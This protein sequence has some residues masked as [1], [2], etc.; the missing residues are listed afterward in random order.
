M[1]IKFLLIG[2]SLFSERIK[3][4]DYKFKLISSLNKVFPGVEPGEDLE[5]I[6]LSGFW[7][8]TISLQCAYRADSLYTGYGRL[9]V[10]G[11][12]KDAVRIREVKLMPSV[13]PCNGECDGHYLSKEPGLYPD[14]ISSIS[15]ERITYIPRQWHALWID[16]EAEEGMEGKQDL[17]LQFYNEEQ[18]LV[19]EVRTEICIYPI[20]LKPQTCFHTE[21]FHCDC[22]AD[23]YQVEPWSV[24]HWEIMR[25]FITLYGKRGMNMILAPAFTP[26]LDTAIGEE[27][28]TV[29]LVDV[30]VMGGKYIFSFEKL[31]AFFQMCMECGVK[32]FEIAHLFTQWGA[33]SAPK[34]MAEKDG[35]LVRIFG[36]ETD[37]QSFA[38]QEFLGQFLDALVLRLDEWNL[39]GRVFFHLSDEPEEKDLEMYRKVRE[40]VSAHLK[41]YPIMDAVSRYAFYESGVVDK[42]VPAVDHLEPFLKH[43]VPG[44]WTYYCTAQGKDVTNRFFAMPSGR[45]RILGVQ[46]Y[47]YGLEGFLHWGFNFYNSQYSLSHINP[48][49]VTDAG[50]AF[51]SG[52]A[53]LVYPGEDGCPEE[54]LRLMALSQAMQDIRAFQMLEE[55]TSREYV[56]DLI[57][58]AA[59]EPITLVSYPYSSQFFQKLREIVNKEIADRK[60]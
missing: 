38:Y 47:Q 41:G 29:Q 19:G 52:D 48:F 18:I 24:P 14:L 56:M 40:S 60:F 34:V 59:E 39:R 6:T 10:N 17:I 42:P 8:E 11:S 22:L 23:Y 25:N 51:P 33:K 9:V 35:T 54:S 16:L 36:W 57:R 26:P 5:G 20:H 50:A 2:M 46:M 27:R 1:I 12:L 4:M 55:L 31:Y 45:T 58:M 43:Q 13:L 28:T 15:L 53:F 7:G 44:L 3:I 49:Q 37:S 32:Y 30:K 21:W